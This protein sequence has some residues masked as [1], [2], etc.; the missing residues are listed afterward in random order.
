MVPLGDSHTVTGQSEVKFN[1]VSDDHMQGGKFMLLT[2]L[3]LELLNSGLIGSDGGALDSDRVLLDGL[4]G[5]NGDLVVGLIT[6]LETEIIVLE[7][8]IKVRV[9]ELVLDRLPD[10][11]GHLIAIELDDGVLD[12]DLVNG[13]HVA[14]ATRG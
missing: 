6:V 4:G 2:L 1:V 8:D 12:L 14:N 10:D 9:D 7:V 11:T 13:S 5:I 3:Q